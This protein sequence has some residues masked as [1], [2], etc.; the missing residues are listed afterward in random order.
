MNGNHVI[1]KQT[2]DQLSAEEWNKLAEDVNILG[3]GN[4]SNNSVADTVIS[5]SSKGNT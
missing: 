4:G 2:G 5:V 3:E 1:T